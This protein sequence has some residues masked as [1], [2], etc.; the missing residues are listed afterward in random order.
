MPNV[1][2]LFPDLQGDIDTGFLGAIGKARRVIEQGFGVAD[3][4]EQWGRSLR[5]ALI[6]AASGSRRLPFSPTYILAM[7]RIISRETSGSCAAREGI[8]PPSASRSTH[9]EMHTPAAGAG[10]PISRNAIS[11]ATVRPPPAESP[12]M[13]IRSGLY[14]C[15]RSHR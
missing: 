2:H 15:A 6:G 10:T 3:L 7:V 11:V 12:A 5:S 13:T 4:D 9:G 8:D 1:R 14:P